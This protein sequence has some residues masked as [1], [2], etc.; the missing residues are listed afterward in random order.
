MDSRSKLISRE[1]LIKRA[2][3]TRKIRQ[4]QSELAGERKGPSV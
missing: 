2:E 3:I 4:F 1:D